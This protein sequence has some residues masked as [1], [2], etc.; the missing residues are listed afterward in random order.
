MSFLPHFIGQ[1]KSQGWP[2]FKGV[3][4]RP[5]LLGQYRDRRKLFL[6]HFTVDVTIYLKISILKN[7]ALI[8][9]VC[10]YNYV[11]RICLYLFCM[12]FQIEGWILLFS[13]I[14]LKKNR[15][16]ENTIGQKLYYSVFL[17]LIKSNLINMKRPLVHYLF[18]CN[19]ASLYMLNI[20]FQLK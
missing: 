7:T 13:K 3:E 16:E 11:C 9:Y 17:N 1:I 10:V 2:R 14:W 12:N 19:S 15:G 18:F 4:N 6:L 5:C 8:S 20:N